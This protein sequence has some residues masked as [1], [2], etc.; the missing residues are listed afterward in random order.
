MS[1]FHW[2][3]G[4]L[5]KQGQEEKRL[6]GH[7]WG[8][9]GQRAAWK[10]HE[11]AEDPQHVKSMSHQRLGS[12]WEALSAGWDVSDRREPLQALKQ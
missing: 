2:S 9:T 8:W 3:V 12:P 10:G 6:S 5:P 4:S 1:L 7:A 11:G